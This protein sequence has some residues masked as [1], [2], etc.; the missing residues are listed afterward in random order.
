MP[1]QSGRIVLIT[2]ANSGIGYE[3]AVALAQQGA[4]VVMACRN[5]TKGEEAQQALLVRVPKASTDLLQLDLGNLQSIRTFAQTFNEKYA[6]LDVLMNN[7]GIM[8]PPYSHTVDGFE[9]QIGT[10]HLGHFALTGLLLP[11]LLQTPQSRIVTV[12]SYANYF[13]WIN[14]ADLQSERRYNGWLAYCQSK[15]ANLLFALELQ[16]KL[17]AAHADARSIA[18]HPGHAATNLQ[19]HPANWFDA[20]WL[21]AANVVIAQNA[22]MGA[23]YQLFAATAPEARGGEFY[24]PKYVTRGPVARAKL[25]RRARDAR[26]AAKLWQISE[27]LTGVHYEAVAQKWRAASTTAS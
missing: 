23:M 18:V 2:G 14:F 19:S 15:L 13:G 22:E 25:T 4:H 5:L 6:R 16:R 1:A 26:A 9:A 12:S 27:E 21:S 20:L 24:G 17:E 7:A 10:N 8:A 3:S 11:P